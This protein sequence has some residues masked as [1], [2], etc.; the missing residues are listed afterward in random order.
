[1][2]SVTAF[3]TSADAPRN[4]RRGILMLLPTFIKAMNFQ[5]AASQLSGTLIA[6]QF[7][8]FLSPEATHSC[9]M[10]GPKV[11]LHTGGYFNFAT[12]VVYVSCRVGRIKRHATAGD[13]ALNT[14]PQATCVDQC[15]APGAQG[16]AAACPPFRKE[17]LTF[18][19]PVELVLQFY[20]Y[21]PQYPS[22][23]IYQIIL[24]HRRNQT[25]KVDGAR[26]RCR[27]SPLRLS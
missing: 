26:R 9:I 7:T 13:S 21:I 27:V 6:S 20:L 4:C 19:V 18:E 8:I 14:A 22:E 24:T 23:H 15:G 11:T 2:I 3:S 17:A 25:T 10:S 16:A 1:M 12:L 5:N